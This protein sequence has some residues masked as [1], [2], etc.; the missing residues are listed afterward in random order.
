MRFVAV[1]EPKPWVRVTMQAQFVFSV[2][3]IRFCHAF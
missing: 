3:F 2:F 1:G